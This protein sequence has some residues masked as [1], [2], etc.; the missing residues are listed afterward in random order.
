MSVTAR[1]CAALIWYWNSE[2]D[3]SRSGYVPAGHVDRLE[4]SYTF[5]NTNKCCFN[6]FLML[7]SDELRELEVPS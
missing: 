6:N 1:L 3:L 2:P 7:G 4:G 5:E